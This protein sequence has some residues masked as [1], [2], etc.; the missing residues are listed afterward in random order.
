MSISSK[1]GRTKLSITVAPET[2]AFLE[3][4]VSRGQA[5]NLA[6]ALDRA[7]SSIRKIEN[8][9]RLADATTRYFS[10]LDSEAIIGE[11]ALAKDMTSAAGTIDFFDKEI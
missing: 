1:T 3:Q 5:A 2:Y 6:E 10:K 4:M 8:R 11:N 7:I 9:K